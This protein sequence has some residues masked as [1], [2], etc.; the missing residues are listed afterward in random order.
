MEVVQH[1]TSFDR[2]CWTHSL[3]LQD[4]ATGGCYV[5]PLTPHPAS[6]SAAS[7]SHPRP[8]HCKV[9]AG[10]CGGL[11]HGRSGGEGGAVL[12][13]VPG[14]A[15]TVMMS[16]SRWAPCVDAGEEA[17]GARGGQSSGSEGV[18]SRVGS[19]ERGFAH[20]QGARDGARTHSLA[21]RRVPPP[22]G[23]P[24]VEARSSGLDGVTSASREEANAGTGGA[25]SA[26][27]RDGTRSPR[28][29]EKPDVMGDGG[30][31]PCRGLAGR[32]VWGRASGVDPAPGDRSWAFG[33]RGSR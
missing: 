32:S 19:H 28:G 6:T 8:S 22:P 9:H 25:E 31:S 24:Q 5:S 27:N 30:G 3:R 2:L 13:E 29:V 11:W 4:Q 33:R 15:E 10:P 26:G 12:L 23:Y 1:S 18:G 14:D 20:R 17:E 7:T 21:H 16:G